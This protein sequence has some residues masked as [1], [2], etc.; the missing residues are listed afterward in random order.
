MDS[1]LVLLAFGKLLTLFE[2]FHL[3]VTQPNRWLTLVVECVCQVFFSLSLDSMALTKLTVL[4]VPLTI[5][6]I[7]SSV[8]PCHVRCGGAC[9]EY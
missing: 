9:I 3:L 1:S 7:S 8:S 4:C 2:A 6:E 5:S